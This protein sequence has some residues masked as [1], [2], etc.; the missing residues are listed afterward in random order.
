LGEVHLRQILQSYT[1]YYTGHWT[2]MHRSLAKFSESEASNHMPSWADFTITMPEL[3]F[4]VHTTAPF[5]CEASKIASAS[6]ATGFTVPRTHR[7]YLIKISR[8]TAPGRR[9]PPIE[10]VLNGGSEALHIPSTFRN[11]KPTIPALPISRF[12][13]LLLRAISITCSLCATPTWS[14]RRLVATEFALPILGRMRS[15]TTKAPVRE[16][17]ITPRSGPKRRCPFGLRIARADGCWPRGMKPNRY[18]DPCRT[19]PSGSSQP[20]TSRAV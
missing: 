17:S 12:P 4:S 19:N 20:V 8:Y 10:G 3:K 7:L 2:K 16:G 13:I 5:G 11:S 18:N 9:C 6:I 15:A 1:R 14:Q